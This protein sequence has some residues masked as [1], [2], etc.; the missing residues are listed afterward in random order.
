MRKIKA[1]VSG[2]ESKLIAER[3]KGWIGGIEQ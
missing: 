1:P 2:I 3:G